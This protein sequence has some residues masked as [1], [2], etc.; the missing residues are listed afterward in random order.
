M[1]LTHDSLLQYVGKWVNIKTNLC[2]YLNEQIVRI[3]GDSLITE[4][5]HHIKTREDGLM[6]DHWIDISR[7]ESIEEV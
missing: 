6:R 2:V 1:E 7:I 5:Y 4:Y 3:K